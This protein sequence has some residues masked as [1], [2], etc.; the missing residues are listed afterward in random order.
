L[1]RLRCIILKHRTYPDR[2]HASC[3]HT[4]NRGFGLNPPMPPVQSLEP[5]F[6]VCSPVCEKGERGER[7]F[8]HTFASTPLRVLPTRNA[9]TRT[10]MG[11]RTRM[12]TR[13]HA[14][15]HAHAHEHARTRNL[16]FALSGGA[17][18]RSMETWRGEEHFS[19]SKKG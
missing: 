17:G 14:Y 9:R 11:T 8:S 19:Q 6:F 7:P 1:L 5:V 10:R 16:F 3:L 13:T 15:A 4:L 18:E 2:G 12:R